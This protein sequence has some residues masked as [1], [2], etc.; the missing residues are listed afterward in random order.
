MKNI[1]S[2]FQPNLAGGCRDY[3]AKEYRGV[4]VGKEYRGTPFGRVDPL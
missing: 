3:S 1:V 2:H 4:H